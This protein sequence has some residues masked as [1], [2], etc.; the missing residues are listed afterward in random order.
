MVVRSSF[1]SISK[2]NHKN[3]PKTDLKVV[4]PSNALL[5]LKRKKR[6]LLTRKRRGR[7]FFEGAQDFFF[8]GVT[9]SLN[10][11][12]LR[13]QNKREANERATNNHLPV[14]AI[15]TNE[16]VVSSIVCESG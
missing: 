10:R 4:S 9:K 12:V 2:P 13:K 3:L 11:I 16:V 15:L 7:R 1:A 5:V 8:V 14:E 6:H